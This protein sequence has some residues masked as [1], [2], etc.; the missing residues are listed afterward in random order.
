MPT[1]LPPLLR[2]VPFRV[3][4]AR[5]LG[6][7]EGRLRGR[8]LA[9]PHHGARS[10]S[11]ESSF[12]DRCWSYLPLLSPGQAFSHV[13][14]AALW[15][16]PLPLATREPLLHVVGTNGCRPR[17]PGVV[18]HRA[19]LVPGGFVAGLPVVEPTVAWAQC[20]AELEV[21]DL[22][23]MGDALVGRWS[24]HIEARELK[25]DKLHAAVEAWGRRRGARR[26]AEALPQ[27]RA[28][29]WS[30][31]ETTLR[32]TL[33]RAGVPEPPGLNAAIADDAGVLL[34]HGDL[35]WPRQRVAVEYE[36]DQHRTDRWQWRSDVAKYESYTDAGWRV[37]RV[38]DDDLVSPGILLERI[39]RL[40]AERALQC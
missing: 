1:A 23:V 37:V 12:H 26:L 2:T 38:T 31:K 33:V 15:G 16:L 36:G 39:T 11:T 40:L 28:D 19:S 14:A 22:I 5:R 13:T 30:P 9:A 24:P 6:V 27:L 25:L 4:E 29:V 8:D 18:G 10:P 35:V 3:G 17:R 34:G 32:L 20:A 21:D 7:G